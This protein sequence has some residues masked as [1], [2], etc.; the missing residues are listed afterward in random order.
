MSKRLVER[1]R[2]AGLSPV[3]IAG[4][5]HSTMVEKPADFLSAVKA[6]TDGAVAH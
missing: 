3:V 5:G 6:F 2:A 4:P 1:Y